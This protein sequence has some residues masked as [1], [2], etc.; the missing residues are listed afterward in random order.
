MNNALLLKLV[1]QIASKQ[2]RTWVEV[3]LAKYC[4]DA[5]FWEL[6]QATIASPLWRQL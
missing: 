6:G 2:E 5:I 4:H 1:W 3:M